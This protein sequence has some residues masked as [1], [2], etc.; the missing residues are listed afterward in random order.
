MNETQYQK[1]IDLCSDGEW[2]CGIDFWNLFIR[3][4]HKRRS[5]IEK[6]GRY[7][8]ESRPCE[9]NHKNVRDYRMFENNRQDYTANQKPNPIPGQETRS[10]IQQ[11]LLKV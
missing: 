3:S 2:H 6:K 1:I 7:R 9:H 5:E 4:P 10:P 8:F 11:E